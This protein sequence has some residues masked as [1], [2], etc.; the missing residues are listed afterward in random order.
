MGQLQNG[1]YGSTGEARSRSNS[2]C[3]YR[4]DGES[5]SLVGTDDWHGID[6]DMEWPGI[7][8]ADNPEEGEWP[9]IISTDS[10]DEEWPG[11]VAD[12]TN[13]EK[14][15]EVLNS[16]RRQMHTRPIKPPEKR[17]PFGGDINVL[18]RFWSMVKDL[19]DRRVVPTGYGLKESEAGYGEYDTVEQLAVG[20]S[21]LN[22]FIRVFLPQKTWQPRIV[23]W[24]QALEAMTTIL[25]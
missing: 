9:G 7:T 12:D 20:R 23:L 22:K 16:I 4:F 17:N 1:I 25:L 21:R 6:P 11:I 15:L 8:T 13:A 14:R 19:Q 2:S 18:R 5:D 24:L 3:D 10:S